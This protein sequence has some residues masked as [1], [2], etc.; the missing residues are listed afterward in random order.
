MQ[1]LCSLVLV[2][3]EELRF[4]EMCLRV[5]EWVSSGIKTEFLDSSFKLTNFN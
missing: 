3:N 1:R 4:K 2:S 5:T